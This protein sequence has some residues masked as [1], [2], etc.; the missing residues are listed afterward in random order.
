MIYVVLLYVLLFVVQFLF[1]V[2]IANKL[3]NG[4]NGLN[5]YLVLMV[6]SALFFPI[7]FAIIDLIMSHVN[8]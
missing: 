3:E 2:M 7:L 1:S 6:I 8:G 5:E 4:L